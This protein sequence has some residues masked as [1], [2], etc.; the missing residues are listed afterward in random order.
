MRT[1]SPRTL[2][3]M[4]AGIGLLCL[5]MAAGACGRSDDGADGDD[6]VA[7]E[8][9]AEGPATGTIEVWAMG[10][11]GE[12]LGG[13]AEAFEE[14]N[15]EASVE[16]TAIPWD[17]AH[18]KL[19]TAIASGQ[20]PDVALIGTTWMGEF[21]SQG[22]LDPTPEGL[23]DPAA[24]YEGAWESTVVDG[25]S[26][27]VPWYVETR[28]LFYRADLAA[29]AGWDQPPS[30]W[31]ELNQFAGDLKDA[32]VE[33]PLF[34]Q[35]G[36]TG[37]WQ[38]MLPFAW[39]A[40]AEMTSDDG[41]SY[42]LDS[43]AMATGLEFYK[44]LFDQDFSTTRSLAAGELETGF[45]DGTIGAFISGPWEIGLTRDA[46]ATDEQLA[47]A[48][49][50][51]QEEGMGTSFIGGGNLAVF[52]DADNREGGWK[53]VQWLAQS[54]TQSS[55][56][57]TVTD[58]PAVREAWDQGTL[59]DDPL[60]S[61]FGEQLESGNA[62]PAVPTWE[63]VAAVIDRDVERVVRGQ[64]DVEEALADMQSQAESIGTGL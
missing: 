13:F 18:D 28:A 4:A 27:G 34:V 3:R 50:P 10:T 5:A 2:R 24:F 55:W 46:G 48:P 19:A 36:Q 63:E 33:T 1:R 53:L 7:A 54:D 31:D 40:G 20:T 25:T 37:S 59:A 26:Y 22:G 62:P 45:A 43:D 11:E 21:A 58:L 42:A 35:P 64:M 56:Y 8:A 30:S 38:T 57:D 47:I 17:A 23:V 44:G 32:G 60:L 14:D 49:L 39:T 29:D 9:I 15:P 51:G 41:A 6:S 16:V 61:V 12:E 52:A